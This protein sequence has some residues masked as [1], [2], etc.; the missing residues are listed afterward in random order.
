VKKSREIVLILDNI[1]S[2]ENVGSIFRTGD[3]I[4]VQKIFLTGMTP[5]PIDRFGRVRKDISKSALGAEKNISWEYFEKTSD[6][7]KKLKKEGF[8][9]VAIEQDTKSLDY[10]KIKPKHKTC[11]IFGNEVS[12]INREILGMADKIAE[13]KMR[14]MKESLNVSVSAGVAL[15]RLFD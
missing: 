8:F 2:A 13:I 12:G 11:L 4:G 10:K 1:R 6:V 5:S 3:A 9:I 7:V 15:Y 14:G